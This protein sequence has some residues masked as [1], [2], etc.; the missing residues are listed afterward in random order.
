MARGFQH[1]LPVSP[2]SKIFE[3]CVCGSYT[4]GSLEP[5]PS[6]LSIFP[7][8]QRTWAGQAAGWS[9]AHRDISSQDMA[10]PPFCL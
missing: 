9:Q 8:S 7:P 4:P 2:H 10:W 6:Q 1:S 3:C 5:F